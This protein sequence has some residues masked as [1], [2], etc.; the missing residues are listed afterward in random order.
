MKER[1]YMALQGSVF[2]LC[3]ILAHGWFA[4]VMAAF[5]AA[6]FLAASFTSK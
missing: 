6:Y 5:A 2:L 3:A 4:G 1:Q